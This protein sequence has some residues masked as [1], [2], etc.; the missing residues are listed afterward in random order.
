MEGTSLNF[1]QAVESVKS[2]KIVTRDGEMLVFMR[3]SDKISIDLIPNIK[4]LPQSVK[5]WYKERYRTLPP[6]VKFSP[7]LCAIHQP[8]GT[9]INGWQSSQTDILA[10]DWQI[11]E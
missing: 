8:S 3:P 4:S 11:I 9:I 5:D 2:G 7:Y 10:E 1:G 6:D